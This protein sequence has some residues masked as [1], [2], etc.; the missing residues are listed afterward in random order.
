MQENLLYFKINGEGH[1]MILLSELNK[2]PYS[3]I[4]RLCEN[5]LKVLAK[6]YIK[7]HFIGQWASSLPT[8]AHPKEGLLLY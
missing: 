7:S 4:S 2:V 8:L 3:P 1:F 5:Q 6:D